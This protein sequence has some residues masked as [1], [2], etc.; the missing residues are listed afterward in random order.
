MYG[1]FP[2][3]FAEENLPIDKGTLKAAKEYFRT[4]ENIGRLRCTV[5]DREVI[6]FRRS[7]KY[8]KTRLRIIKMFVLSDKYYSAEMVAAY[9]LKEGKT[10]KNTAV[11]H[12]HKINELSRKMT[13]I[14][15][16]VCKRYEGYTLNSKI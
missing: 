4:G 16:I 7:L 9:C 12:I 1:N 2:I 3:I 8:T 15:L 5:N 11:S 13:G 6:Y 14:D 10:Q